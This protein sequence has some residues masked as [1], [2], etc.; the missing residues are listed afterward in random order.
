MSLHHAS[1][2]VKIDK[3]TA[4]NVAFTRE[5]NATLEKLKRVRNM[6]SKAAVLRALVVEAGLR[7]EES[8]PAVFQPPAQP[9]PGGAQ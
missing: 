2:Q 8:T 3:K 6:P 7:L 1:P 4:T 5:E 9:A